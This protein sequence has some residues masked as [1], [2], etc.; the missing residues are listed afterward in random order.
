M[1]TLE[2]IYDRDTNTP[3]LPML[4]AP[5]EFDMEGHRASYRCIG[6]LLAGKGFAVNRDLPGADRPESVTSLMNKS[7]AWLKSVD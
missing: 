4:S 6:W 1:L 5:S 2:A 3:V 7:F